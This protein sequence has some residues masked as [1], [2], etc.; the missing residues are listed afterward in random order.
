MKRKRKRGVLKTVITAILSLTFLASCNQDDSPF[1]KDLQNRIKEDYAIHLNKRGRE[2]DEKY[3][4]SNLFIINFFGIYDGAVIVLMDRLAPQPLSMQKIA[5]VAFYYPDGNY[6]Q[7]WKDGV[8][9][10]MP[11]AYEAGVL[12]YDHL[13]EAAEIINDE[14][15][16]VKE[17]FE[18]R[19]TT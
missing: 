3:T 7:V 10:E 17:A 5:G 14:F 8:F 2:S 13:L 11:A 4:A 6:T 18:T 9:Y 1:N 12:T 16:Y 19:Q 15:D